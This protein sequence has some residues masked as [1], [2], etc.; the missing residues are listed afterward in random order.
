MRGR[1]GIMMYR[2]Y[3]RK[4]PPFRRVSAGIGRRW[5]LH[6]VKQLLHDKYI[7]SN[8]YK[9]AIPRYYRKILMLTADDF[10]EYIARKQ[11]DLIKRFLRV[12]SL[13]PAERCH[14]DKYGI[15]DFFTFKSL[16]SKYL[17]WLRTL[18]LDYETSREI[19]TGFN[20]LLL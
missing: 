5:C 10:V 20:P 13:T 15:K 18:E 3:Y 6:R 19:K 2:Y 11:A 14:Y 1:K 4:E 9:R 16:C 12:D 7:Y 8:G 17:S